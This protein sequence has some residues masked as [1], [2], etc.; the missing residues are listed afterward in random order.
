MERSNKYRLRSL[1]RLSKLLTLQTIV[2]VFPNAKLP[3]GECP[4]L[5]EM[6]TQLESILCTVVWQDEELQLTEQ[7][8]YKVKIVIQGTVY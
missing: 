1:E 7:N 6:T 3:T 4:V 2:I 5:A 8:L